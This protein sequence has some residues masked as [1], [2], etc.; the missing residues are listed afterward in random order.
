MAKKEQNYKYRLQIDYLSQAQHI[1]IF[2]KSS[3]NCIHIFF[4]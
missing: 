1:S 3:K 2:F 4:N